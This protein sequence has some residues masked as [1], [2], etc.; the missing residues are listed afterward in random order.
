MVAKRTYNRIRETK[1]EHSQEITQLKEDIET[2]RK[3][4]A[5]VKVSEADNYKKIELLQRK[6]EQIQ[7]DIMKRLGIGKS[8]Y[9]EILQNRHLPAD[10]KGAEKYLLDYYMVYH[11]EEFNRWK[12]QYTE[13]TPRMYTYLILSSMGKSSDEIEQI[14]SISPSSLRS[15]KSRISAREKR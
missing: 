4:L 12:E 1:D 6:I 2:L 15:L 7:N 8:L 10:L 3:E 11:Q 9:N 14:L 13:L 5:N